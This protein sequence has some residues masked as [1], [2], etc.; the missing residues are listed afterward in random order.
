[1]PADTPAPREDAQCAPANF[2]SYAKYYDSLY[3]DKDYAAESAFVTGLLADAGI[4]VGASLLDLGC[5]TGSHLVRLLERGYRVTGVDRSAEMLEIAREKCAAAGLNPPLVLGDVR[6]FSAG[7]ATSG[8]DPHA[9]EDG[10]G[11]F[12]GALMMFAVVSYLTSD[13]DLDAA[14]RRVAAHLRPGGLFVF[15]GWY[16]PGVEADLPARRSRTLELPDGALLTREAT[17]SID[18]AGHTVA[19]NYHLTLTVDGNLA[20]EV[21]EVHDMRYRFTAEI[22]DALN[23]AGMELVSVCPELRAGDAPSDRDWTVVWVARKRG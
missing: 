8:T 5:G 23:R 2:R 17:P 3:G 15:D 7:S 9:D 19:V 1:M 4:G 21:R 22:E 11:S 13:D 10:V 20:D 6:D 12:D 16:G 18:R 14:F